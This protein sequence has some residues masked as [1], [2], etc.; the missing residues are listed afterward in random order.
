[1]DKRQA[2]IFSTRDE[3]PELREAL[4]AFIVSLAERV[5]LLQDAE[6]GEDIQA[7]ALLSLALSE[8][9]Q[10]LGFAPLAAVARN[11]QRACVESKLEAVQSGVVELTE[12]SRRI[13]LGHRGAF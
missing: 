4:D 3:D 11:V 7:L 1:M 9:A 12:I 6:S 5:D 8:E 2:P 13:R 10:D